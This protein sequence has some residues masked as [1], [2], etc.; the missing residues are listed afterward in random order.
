MKL[1]V[2]TLGCA[3]RSLEESAS[4]CERFGIGGIELR[5]IGSEMDIK[6]IP[7]FRPENA[8]QSAAILK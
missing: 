6:K 3:E 2:S 5:G 4:L 7:D 1:C 8:A